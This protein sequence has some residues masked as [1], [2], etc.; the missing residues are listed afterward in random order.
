M[1]SGRSEVHLYLCAALYPYS[2]E[3][4][5]EPASM[6]MH[7]DYHK[8]G[9]AQGLQDQMEHRGQQQGT[10]RLFIL[11][12]QA[13]QW[14]QARRVKVCVNQGRSAALV[15]IRIFY[16]MALWDLRHE[17]DPVCRF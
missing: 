13:I 9:S 16:Y 11:T 17:T 4:V 15:N 1:K 10:K 5:T 7:P 6:A 3:C 12:T 14:F 2:D 8:S